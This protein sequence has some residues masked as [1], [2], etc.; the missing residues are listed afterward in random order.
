MDASNIMCIILKIGADNEDLKADINWKRFRNM[1]MHDCAHMKNQC[2]LILA[3]Q[4]LIYTEDKIPQKKKTRVTFVSRE[5][6]PISQ[7]KSCPPAEVWY[8][9]SLNSSG[10]EWESSDT[11]IRQLVGCFNRR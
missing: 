7:R 10:S 11:G 3:N 2:L 6:T 4:H 1:F 9:L 8:Q 5:E